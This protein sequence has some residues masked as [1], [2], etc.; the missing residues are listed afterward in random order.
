MKLVQCWD[1]GVTSD[2]RLVE[3]LRAVGARATFNLNAGLHQ[4]RRTLGWVH[5]STEVWRL[6]RGELPEVYHGFDIA[7][8]SLN[9]PCLD[10]LPP[11]EARLEIEQG[12][13]QLEQIFGR[14]VRG[15]VYPFGR[16][17]PGVV[18]AVRQTGHLY[19]RT[20]ETAETADGPFAPADPMRLAP[21][22]HFQAADFWHR[23]DRAR[24]GGVFY[25]WGHSY[26]MTGEADWQA[27]GRVLQRLARVPGAR[28]CNVAELFDGAAR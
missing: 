16:F 13:A 9:H 7:N 4:D 6:A 10:A 18:E 2:L 14:P 28:W 25:F 3:M 15:F 1:D 20:T 8:H 21:H 17:N 26:E 5:G 24:P 19:G 12:R 22:C 11:G 23:F 27:Y